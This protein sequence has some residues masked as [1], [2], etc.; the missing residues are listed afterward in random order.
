MRQDDMQKTHARDIQHRSKPKPVLR[1]GP[2]Y[3]EDEKIAA[4]TIMLELGG[5]TKEAITAARIRL[6]SNVSTTTLG[7]W[8]NEYQDKVIAA[9]TELA[10]RPVNTAETV[11]ATQAGLVNDLIAIQRLIVDHIVTDQDEVVGKAS[12]RD[13]M[14]SLGIS[15]DKLEQWL[16]ISPD[17]RDRWNKLQA[18]CLPAGLDPISMFDDFLAALQKHIATLQLAANNTT[19]R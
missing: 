5:L 15:S 9:K 2:H 7:K 10:P 6:N 13:S 19:A 16:S 14:V 11:R 17:A 18:L 8:K 12:L 1:R 4:V 3:S